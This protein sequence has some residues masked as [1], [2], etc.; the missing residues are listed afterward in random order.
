MPAAAWL[1]RL[2][3][4][5]RRRPA[6]TGVIRLAALIADLAAVRPSRRDWATAGTASMMN[7]VFDIGC[8]AACC[9]AFDVHVALGALLTSYTAGMAA[10]GLSPLPTGIGIVETALILAVT[11]A[12][13]A[14]PAAV[15][16]VITYR[17]ISS[18]GVA[19]VG[20]CILA[21]QRYRPTPTLTAK[22]PAVKQVPPSR[23]LDSR[24]AAVLGRELRRSI[25]RLPPSDHCPGRRPG[26]SQRQ[27]LAAHGGQRH[28]PS[29][30]H[31]HQT[32]PPVAVTQLTIVD[33][34][35]RA[36]T[37]GDGGQFPEQ[38]S[39]WWTITVPIGERSGPL[40]R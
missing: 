37:G 25:Q 14:A 9:A 22:V 28:P 32:T 7:W 17:L 1:L 8:L 34:G 11:T 21:V 36:G 2:V 20:W 19:V 39:P 24:S 3:N 27:A 5:I 31:H 23:G 10:A 29:H 33:D 15:D 38:G 13:A 16:T 40:F 26:V 6:G 4:P 30:P 18:G 35:R 12:G